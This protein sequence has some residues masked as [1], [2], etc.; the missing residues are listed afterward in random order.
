MLTDFR[1][2]VSDLGDR[3]IRGYVWLGLCLAFLAGALVVTGVAI[4]LSTLALVGIGWLDTVISWLGSLATAII[5]I[6][7]FPATVNLVSSVFLDRVAAAVERRH[8]PHAAETA[9]EVPLS[10]AILSGLRLFVV[11]VVLNLALLPVYLVLPGVNIAIYLLVNGYLLGREFHEL[12]ALRH[13]RAE[14]ATALRRKR[15]FAVVGAG[16]LMT[17]IATVPIV[18]LVV[19]VL[20]AA[21]FTH[22]FQTLRD[23]GEI[24]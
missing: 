11:A 18:N 7:L 15:R 23:P 3:R 19:P 14:E 6:L 21:F 1:K 24:G 12:V 5:A 13:L 4:S 10:T 16:I 8:Y 20:S 9:R 2:A 22:R 17:A